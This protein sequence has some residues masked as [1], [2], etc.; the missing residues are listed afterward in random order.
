LSW[1]SATTA[2]A[3]RMAA[4]SLGKM[5][6][7]RLRRLSSLLSSSS[8]FVLQIWRQW[9]RGKVRKGN[10]SVFGLVDECGRL[11]ETAAEHGLDVVPLGGDLLGGD[12]G[13][14]GA[15][16]GSHHLLVASGDVGQ[17]PGEVDPAALVAR[18]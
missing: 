10:T 9:A 6:T 5:P 4:A 1:M 7:T 14:D 2:P 3:R 16:G 17:V 12:L 8:E 15:E 11:V 13:E 18:S